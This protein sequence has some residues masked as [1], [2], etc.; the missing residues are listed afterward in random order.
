VIAPA[1]LQLALAAAAAPQ[2]KELVLWHR[3]EER[4]QS[5]ERSLDG[6]LGVW[7]KDL[8]TGRVLEL[9]ARESFPT[10][11][12]IKVAVLYELY[13][14]AEQGDIDL[15][16]TTR[17]PLP[18]VGGG[19]VLESLGDKVNITWRDLAVL[20]MAFSDN[21]AT[22]VLI[23]KLGMAAVNRRLDG[24]GLGGVR[25]RRKMMDLD[26]ARRGD[27]NIATPEDLGR[28]SEIVYRGTGLAVERARDMLAVATL[29]KWGRTTST[30]SP[31]RIGLPEAL[32]I[33]DKPGE[34]SGVR[35]VTASVDLK[36]RPYV[37]TLM[38]TFLRREADGESAIRDISQA[39]YET[40]D[41]LARSSEL[42]RVIE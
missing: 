10:A 31:F 18:R 27:E 5:I 13:K 24:L 29:D 25:L 17:P 6:V 33:A 14:R 22:N 30:P 3:L 32:V 23:D 20:M 12:S 7:V 39:L 2:A 15:Q 8:K 41:R 35:C 38:T 34:L 36:G 42:G 16:E 21:E 11:S 9:R 4:I 28:L 19:G 1:L 26:A 40:F 37:A